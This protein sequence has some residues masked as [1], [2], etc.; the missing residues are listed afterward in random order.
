MESI[1]ISDKDK[2]RVKHRIRSGELC[3]FEVWDNCIE[4]SFS[5]QPVTEYLP[6]RMYAEFCDLL[7]DYKRQKDNSVKSEGESAE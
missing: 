1:F 2:L 3:N 4:L 5:C 7:V 6:P